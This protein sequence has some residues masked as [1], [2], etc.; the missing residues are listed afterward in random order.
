M[1]DFD[2]EEFKSKLESDHKKK[3]QSERIKHDPPFE[4]RICHHDRC[5]PV[6][7]LGKVFGYPSNIVGWCCKG[8]SVRFESVEQFSTLKNKNQWL[9]DHGYEN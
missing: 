2:I 9:K 6:Y 1:K 8:C 4:C 3:L 5:E 7:Q